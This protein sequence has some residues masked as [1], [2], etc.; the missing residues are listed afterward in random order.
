MIVNLP[1]LGAVEFPDNLTSAQYDDLVG[2]LATKYDFKIPKPEASLSTI[3]KRGFMR[4]MG[5]LG[6]AAGD[7]LPAM[8]GSALGFDDYAK[9]QM[10]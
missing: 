5:E 8:A 10:E 3:A 7:V 6:I 2:R 9:R 1:K 4:S